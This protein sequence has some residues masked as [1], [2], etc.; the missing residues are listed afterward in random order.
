M[1]EGTD[2]IPSPLHFTYPFCYEPH[3]L[4]V[5]AAESITPACRQLLINE[6]GGKMFGVLIV[7]DGEG[8]RHFLAAFSGIL[9]GT[10]HHPGFVPPIYDLQHPGSYF[11]EEQAV[12]SDINRKLD[13]MDADHPAAP[14]LREERRQ[15]S[16]QLQ[17]W[18]FQQFHILNAHSES[19]ELTDIFK[20]E[21]QILTAEEYY[22][23][24]NRPNAQYRQIRL[25][26]IPPAGAGECCAPKLL[27]YAYL[28]HLHPL[29]MAEFWLG[30][31]PRDE[32]RTD[33]HYYPAC[34]AKC[35]P[36]L[37]HMLQG[38]DI[39][40]NPMLRRNREMV[41]KVEYLYADT[42]IAVVFKPSGL[43]S[44]PGKDDVPSLLDV[45]RQRYP[46]AMYAHRLDMDTS[47]IMVFALHPEAYRHLQ[48]QFYRHEVTKSYVA[49]LDGE[50]SDALPRSGTITLPLLA[51][52]FD[53]PR[54]M[55]NHEHGKQAITHYDI[56]RTSDG[57]TLL[58]FNP[59]TGRTHQLRVHSA[60][61][62]GLGCPIK[63]DNLYGTP[64]DRLYL[65]ASHLSFT[66]PSTSE[67]MTFDKAPDW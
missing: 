66:H 28:H 49:I 25:Q 8:R 64:S 44:S 10:Y 40:E 62:E 29:C 31:S 45:V 5:K 21:K 20:D 33:G 67:L 50:V 17:Y 32:L 59:Q 47:G 63:G 37:A 36:I 3:P 65:H 60:H 24:K 30:P 54:Q 4:C 39:E 48:G 46:D 13:A 14:E 19:K 61:A 42:D 57:T 18:L 41:S 9:D 12:I 1:P 38:L 56:V 58:H 15:R 51:N 11:Q 27:Q 16:R 23:R 55:V 35:R 43:L 34:H 7:A 53:R 22:A 52:P 2:H 6:T 26:P